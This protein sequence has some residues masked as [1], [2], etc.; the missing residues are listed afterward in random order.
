M[1]SSR[2]SPPAPAMPESVRLK[3]E[4]SSDRAEP[5]L[6]VFLWTFAVLSAF[7][8]IAVIEWTGP[9]DEKWTWL[10]PL[11]ITTIVAARLAWLMAAGERR[12][13]EV[14]F[15]IYTY[16]FMGLAPLAQLRENVWP[17]I[18]PRIDPAQTWAALLLVL[19]GIFAFLVGLRLSK[20]GDHDAVRGTTD[21]ERFSVRYSRILLLTCFAV[22]LNLYYLYNAG[23][24]QFLYSREQIVSRIQAAWPTPPTAILIR[25]ATEMS[26]LVV[27]IALV[28]Y[29]REAKALHG[30]GITVSA[31]SLRTNLVLIVVTGVL[32]ANVLNP[33]SN[34]RYYFGTA[35]LAVIA[36]VGGY[37][38][39][40]RFRVSTVL[41]IGSLLVVFPV[42]SSE[43]F[44]GKGQLDFSSFS[45]IDSFLS[46]DYDSFAQ[47]ANGHLIATREGIHVG[48]QL[49]GVLTFFVPRAWWPGKPVD[50]GTYIAEAR[51]YPVTNLSAPFWI[52]LFL[53]GGLCVLIVGM[54]LL[55][56]LVHR[57]DTRIAAQ[58]QRFGMPGI[59]G[60]IL[61]FYAFILLRGSWLQA[62]PYL[63]AVLGCAYF[64]RAGPVKGER[65]G[66]TYPHSRAEERTPDLCDQYNPVARGRSPRGSR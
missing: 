58:L 16:T 44:R 32:A 18:V 17:N 8:P 54:F 4:L 53:N 19:A 28:R 36:A 61:P 66:E 23:F 64:V 24:L 43:A 31:T 27:W 21:V 7:G 6:L 14:V 57:W 51:G 40:R 26:L 63:I 42:A 48:Q 30:A 35:I 41:L 59:L 50:T 2:Q 34:A 13:F 15:W 37:A 20:S 39:E 1:P 56:Y 22:S 9:P 46:P 47:I 10:G 33:I 38:T 62:M 12:L 25:A 11:A 29:R 65:L 45:A 52:E 3:V 5:S 49:L 60:C 55:G